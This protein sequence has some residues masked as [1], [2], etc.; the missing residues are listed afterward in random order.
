MPIEI[1]EVV[2]KTV[3]DP[4]SGKGAGTPKSGAGGGGSASGSEQELVDKILQVL[5]DKEER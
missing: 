2:I 4:E 3:V 1:K 5:E